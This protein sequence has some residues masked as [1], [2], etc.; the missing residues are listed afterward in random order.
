[1][2]YD[3]LDDPAAAAS[4]TGVLLQPAEVAS[5]VGR[6]LDHPAPS[7]PSRARAGRWWRG[8]G[9]GWRGAGRPTRQQRATYPRN[10]T[11]EGPRHPFYPASPPRNANGLVGRSS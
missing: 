1:M 7:S 8:A 4:F 10:A 2:L 6:L 9:D 11:R 3:K 5:H